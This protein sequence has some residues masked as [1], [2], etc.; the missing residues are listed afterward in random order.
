MMPTAIPIDE[1]VGCFAYLEVGGPPYAIGVEIGK[2]FGWEIHQRLY[3]WPDHARFLDLFTGDAAPL[4]QALLE[5]AEAFCPD[6]VAELRGI[7]DGA[8]CDFRELFLL[9]CRGDLDE[10]VG[11]G[12]CTTVVA[13]ARDGRVLL[14][15]N[16]DGGAPQAGLFYVLRVEPDDA[17]GF[18]SLTY[19]GQIPGNGPTGNE[20]GIFT[21]TNYIRAPGAPVGVPRY[22][23]MRRL[24][25]VRTIDEALAIIERA[26]PQ[27]GFH[28]TIA[29]RIESRAV[30]VEIAP[31]RC[32]VFEIGDRYVHTNHYV[33]DGLRDDALIAARPNTVI[34]YETARRRLEALGPDVTLAGVGEI[35]A[36]HDEEP[37]TICAH[38]GDRLKR[39]TLASLLVDTSSRAM[40]IFTGNPCAAL[41][42][43]YVV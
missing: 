22:F 27:F 1:P 11:S 20:C 10:R 18:V 42:R 9:T 34:R 17:P 14:G 38:P 36:S 41:F 26:E 43:D 3:R 21:V 12:Q 13:R 15:H 40:R 33:G 23:V 29:S 31:G 7:A 19:A 37:H 25:S 28:I 32:C 35:M 2:H 39:A 30:G 8:G 6:G 5:R 24:M 16:E 4:Y